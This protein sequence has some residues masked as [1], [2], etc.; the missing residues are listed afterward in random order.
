MIIDIMKSHRL[1]VLQN[2]DS[3]GRSVLCKTAEQLLEFLL[4]MFQEIW[5]PVVGFE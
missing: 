4:Y 1:K 2:N 5:K 3:S